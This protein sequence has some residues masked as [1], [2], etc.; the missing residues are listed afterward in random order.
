M[1]VVDLKVVG[2]ALAAVAV[3]EFRL[4]QHL[5]PLLPTVLLSVLVVLLVVNVK[6]AGTVAIVY[7]MASTLAVAVVEAATTAVALTPVMEKLP[8]ALEAEALVITTDK[9]G[10]TQVADTVPEPTQIPVVLVVVV[11][12]HKT[13]K[14]AAV[15]EQEETENHL[16]FLVQPNIMVVVEPRAIATVV[17]V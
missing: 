6:A 13:A 1:A 10:A 4:A 11:Q 3:V 14:Q 8:V 7:S 16:T 2:V 17:V 12:H 9:D 5:F 15:E